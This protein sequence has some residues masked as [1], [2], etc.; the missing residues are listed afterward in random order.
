MSKK[1]IA[2]KI[3]DFVGSVKFVISLV[4]FITIWCISGQLLDFD[5][6]PYVFLNLVLGIFLAIVSTFIMI[7]Q[8][9]QSDYIKKIVESIKEEEDEEKIELQ[10][11]CKQL[12]EG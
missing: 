9:R 7:S 3:A 5:P 4:I 6:Y 11:I 1:D 2:D 8:N 12:K 10:D